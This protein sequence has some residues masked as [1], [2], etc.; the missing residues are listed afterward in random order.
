MLLTQ[1]SVNGCECLVPTCPGKGAVKPIVGALENG[2]Q[3]FW[4]TSDF[5]VMF[6]DSLV[7]CA[8]SFCAKKMIVFARRDVFLCVCGGVSKFSSLAQLRD[9]RVWEGIFFG[10]W[11]P[12][13]A[14]ATGFLRFY[15]LNMRLPQDL[16]LYLPTRKILCKKC[17]AS[18]EKSLFY[19]AHFQALV[20]W[21]KIRGKEPCKNI[22][23][24]WK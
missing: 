11:C 16:P 18:A 10:Y 2:F 7:N 19:K 24:L 20:W 21:F 5:N 23:F 15:S 14:C 4:Q 8:M 12:N 6:W 17:W 3:D 22:L 9:R 1:Y 13:D